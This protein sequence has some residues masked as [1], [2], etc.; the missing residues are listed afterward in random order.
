MAAPGA[1]S[2]LSPRAMRAAFV[3][4]SRL[5]LGGFPYAEAERTAGLGHLPLV[6]L[7][8]GLLAYASLALSAQLG[9]ALAASLALAA[10]VA[11]TGALHEDGLADSADALGAA[12]GGK[13]ALEIMKDS[14]IGSFGATALGLSLLVRWSA[15]SELPRRAAVACVLVA[16][17]SRLPPVWLAARLPRVGTGSGSPPAGGA[18]AACATLSALAIGLC[19]T[20]LCGLSW[21][22]VAA[23]VL[24][25]P[26]VTLWAGRKWLRLVGGVTGD[27]LGATQQIAECV[28]WVSCAVALRWAG[29]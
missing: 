22:L 16:V 26:A 15:L 9:P 19:C 11:V 8:V 3:Y 7:V 24:P 5:P 27:L 4:F 12:H 17:A 23:L 20:A 13:R 14:R 1:V 25:L 18:P 2:P 28:L 21:V 29:A 6:G 10:G